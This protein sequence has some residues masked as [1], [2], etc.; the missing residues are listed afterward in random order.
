MRKNQY[1]FND[2][3]SL[4]EMRSVSRLEDKF[5][6]DILENRRSWSTLLKAFEKSVYT[7]SNWLPADMV[8]LI[9]EQRRLNLKPKKGMEFRKENDKLFPKKSN[10]A[11]N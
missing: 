1:R 6:F 11:W 8:S 4:N 2:V 9:C 7:T 10:M 3:R 5:K